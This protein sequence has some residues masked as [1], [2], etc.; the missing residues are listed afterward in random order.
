MVLWVGPCSGIQG[1]VLWKLC[2]KFF[3]ECLDNHRVTFSVLKYCV[4]SLQIRLSLLLSHFLLLV[5]N[6]LM[7]LVQG[8][9]GVCSSMALSDWALLL[10]S[11]LWNLDSHGV[12]LSLLV[13]ELFIYQLLSLALSALFV[14]SLGCWHGVSVFHQLN[15]LLRDWV[16]MRLS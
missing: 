2:S 12:H 3:S 8:Q 13:F 15:N 9:T 14:K 6:L 11:S 5:L 10:V 4:I 7:E 1:I 16:D